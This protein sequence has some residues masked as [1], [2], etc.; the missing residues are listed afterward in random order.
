MLVV[1]FLVL[2]GCGIQDAKS[3]RAT[4]DFYFTHINSPVE[5]DL[6]HSTNFKSAERALSIRF[7]KLDRE[8]TSLAR[9]MDG[10]LDPTK[11][12]AVAGLLETFPWLSNAYV[13]D[14]DALIMGAI[15][16]VASAS[17]EFS[18][19]NGKERKPRE[20]YAHAIKDGESTIFLLARPY[21][22]SG[23]LVGYLAVSFDPRALLPLVGDA[24][25]VFILTLGN[26][27]WADDSYVSNP[28]FAGTDWAEMIDKR[29]SGSISSQGRTATWIARYYANTSLIFGNIE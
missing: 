27:L 17:V 18:Y 8:L 10:I 9:T 23:K 20:L 1:N 11:Q 28:G 21:V 12:P 2:G 16:S 15:P 24:S 6:D 19:L 29:S 26:V 13:L 22:Q 14:A 25:N 5:L 7:A 4:K 3:V